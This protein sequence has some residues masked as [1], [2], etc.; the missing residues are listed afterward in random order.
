MVGGAPL[1]VKL[2]V[3][4]KGQGVILAETNKAAEGV[5]NAMKSLNAN[6]LVQEFI[7]EANG[8]DLRCFVVGGKVVAAIE[9]TAAPGDY[10]A[11]LHQGVWQDKFDLILGAQ[12]CRRSSEGIGVTSLWR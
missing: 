3:G 9:R 4:T 10:R 7:R 8:S 1:I 5:I 2:L 11:N 12:A 6:L